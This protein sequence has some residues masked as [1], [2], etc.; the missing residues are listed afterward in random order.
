MTVTCRMND[1]APQKG[2]RISHRGSRRRRMGV[3]AGARQRRRWKLV[4][5]DGGG[6]VVWT[7]TAGD[8]HDQSTETY[9]VVSLKVISSCRVAWRIDRASSPP[10]ESHSS[11]RRVRIASLHRSARPRVARR[12]PAP[13][14]RAKGVSLSA[15]GIAVQSPSGATVASLS[16]NGTTLQHECHLVQDAD[17]ARES[18]SR[19]GGRG[20]VR[21][22]ESR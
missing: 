19:A 2:S 21:A 15:D 10:S 9:D 7:A 3:T 16:A 13:C 11:P 22:R 6:Y 5:F 8:S 14:S 4:A 20:W 12:R 17:Q 18:E 1:A